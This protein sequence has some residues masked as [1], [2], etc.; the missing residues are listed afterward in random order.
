MTR[1]TYQWIQYTRSTDDSQLTS[2]PDDVVALIAE[3]FT[4]NQKLKLR[5]VCKQFYRQFCAS[6][7]E[8]DFSRRNTEKDS[9]VRDTLV[10]ATVRFFNLR[11]LILSSMA[12]PQRKWGNHCLRDIAMA[13]RELCSVSVVQCEDIT[14][15]G[16]TY[17]ASK[18][19][20][21]VDLDV[22]YCSVGDGALM[23]LAKHCPI[24]RVLRLTQHQCT[25]KGLSALAA[26][27]KELEVLDLSSPS[28]ILSN[29]VLQVVQ[30]CRKLEYLGL[31][32]ADGLSEDVVEAML[33]APSL[34]EVDAQGGSLMWYH[35][36]R[37]SRLN[38]YTK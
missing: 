29:G 12:H 33:N 28:T 22:R 17:L 35:Q 24:L 21:L 13:C 9:R 18:C 27:C 34:V 7:R 36:F 23:A 26:E 30:E 16:I 14:D 1:T 15:L 3:Y 2:I 20:N 8:I 6:V 32:L 10:L 38:R 11:S 4:Y 31:R 19:P 37:T 5:L 25:N